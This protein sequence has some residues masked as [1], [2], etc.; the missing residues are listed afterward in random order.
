MTTMTITVRV[1]L[2]DERMAAAEDSRIVGAYFKTFLNAL[3][4]AFDDVT[5]DARF[6]EPIDDIHDR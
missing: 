2:P 5:F 4:L 1:K 6:E 3:E